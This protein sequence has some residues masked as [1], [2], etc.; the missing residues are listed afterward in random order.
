MPNQIHAAWGLANAVALADGGNQNLAVKQ[1]I[2]ILRFTSQ[3]I[4]V[5]N[6]V[7]PNGLGELK[8]V[9]QSPA[10]DGSAF[11]T[12]FQLAM[13]EKFPQGTTLPRVWRAVERLAFDEKAQIDS[14]GFGLDLRTKQALLV[15]VTQGMLKNLAKQVDS[16]EEAAR[17]KPVYW[18]AENALVFQALQKVRPS[19]NILIEPQL[20]EREGT[21]VV[22]LGKMLERIVESQRFLRNFAVALPKGTQVDMEGVN[23]SSVLGNVTLY[24]LDNLL[25]GFKVNFTTLHTIDTVARRIASAA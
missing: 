24:F 22:V 13:Q 15:V 17:G 14:P 18:V 2:E 6:I 7:G 8:A 12:Q 1:I 20:V 10:F 9:T 3:K 5:E 16:F 4:N 23:E 21:H 25:V 11:R 19:G